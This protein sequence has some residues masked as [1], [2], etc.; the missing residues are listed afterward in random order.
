MSKIK[1]ELNERVQKLVTKYLKT[2]DIDLDKLANKALK[3]YLLEHL[4]SS[5]IKE[6]LRENDDTSSTYSGKLF[7]NNIDD[8][9]L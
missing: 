2:Y 1:I 3:A 4:S 9:N 7:S 8:L 5:Q 6:A